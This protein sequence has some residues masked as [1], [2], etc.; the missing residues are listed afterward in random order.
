MDT[1]DDKEYDEIDQ[2]SKNDEERVTDDMEVFKLG[3]WV[4]RKWW[5]YWEIIWW[6]KYDG[7]DWWQGI[8][9]KTSDR[10]NDEKIVTNDIEVL[11]L[12]KLD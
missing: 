8:W 1:S 4:Q 9:W 10:W 12:G 7:Y 11:K 5:Q 6:K 2:I 3:N